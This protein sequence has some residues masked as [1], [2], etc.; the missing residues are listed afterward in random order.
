MEKGAV[1]TNKKE[2]RRFFN[3]YFVSIAEGF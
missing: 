3:D 1:I 2:I